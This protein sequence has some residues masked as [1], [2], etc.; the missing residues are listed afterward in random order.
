M[1]HEKSPRITDEE[2]LDALMTSRTVAEAAEKLGCARETVSRRK[3]DREFQAKLSQARAERHQAIADR[4]DATMTAALIRLGQLLGDEPG[5]FGMTTGQL[6]SMRLRAIDLWLRTYFG[7]RA[8]ARDELVR[9]LEERLDGQERELALL[10]SLV[11]G[12]NGD[13]LKVPP[14]SR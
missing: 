3:A 14:Y 1:D 13:G 10:R 6:W 7:V 5:N 11:M 9:E 4:V 8:A 12:S 2:I